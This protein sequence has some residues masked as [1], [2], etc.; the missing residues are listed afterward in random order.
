MKCDLQRAEAAAGRPLEMP[1]D[2]SD[3]KIVFIVIYVKII[4]L[5]LCREQESLGSKN[6]L[7][8]YMCCHG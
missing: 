8:M 3:K 1:D 6:K 7:Y 4:L 2:S 5:S